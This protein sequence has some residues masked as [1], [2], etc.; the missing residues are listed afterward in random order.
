MS[1]DR[2][3]Q[4]MADRPVEVFSS[5]ILIS[6]GLLISIFGPGH[7]AAALGTVFST[8]GGVLLS[9]ATATI[10]TN[11]QAALVLRPQLESIRRHLGTVSGQIAHVSHASGDDDASFALA[12]VSQ[13]SRTLY[14]IVNDLQSLTG[15]RFDPQ[16][17]IDTVD[18]VELLADRLSSYTESTDAE[19]DE[20]PIEIAKEAAELRSRIEARF[21]TPALPRPRRQEFVQCP[22]CHGSVPWMIGTRVGDSAKPHCPTCG[23]EFHAHR[24]A[25]GSVVVRTKGSAS[26]ISTYEGIL[27]DQ[28][29]RLVPPVWRDLTLKALVDVMNSFPDGRASSWDEIEQKVAQRLIGEGQLG[30]LLEVKKVRQLAFRAR[31]FRLDPERGISLAANTSRENISTRVSRS[32]VERVYREVGDKIDLVELNRV[33]NGGDAGKVSEVEATIASLR[34][35]GTGES[36]SVAGLLFAAADERPYAGPAL[37]RLALSRVPCASTACR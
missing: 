21:A 3:K 29:L 30:S 4:T 1:F 11:E 18:Q 31:A 24:M 7:S 17:L 25:D 10:K 37:P 15:T 8:V 19:H 26:T 20:V 28:G 33:I 32:L 12:L 16:D 6:G 23:T 35:S 13:A 5:I 27:K 34:S 22:S 2:L 9:W 36:S 14:T